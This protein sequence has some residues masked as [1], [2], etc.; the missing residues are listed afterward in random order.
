MCHHHDHH[1]PT[2]TDQ[3]RPST[4]TLPTSTHPRTQ[5]HPPTHSTSPRLSDSAQIKFAYQARGE[6]NSRSPR[7]YQ[8][9][10]VAL[11]NDANNLEAVFGPLPRAGRPGAQEGPGGAGRPP[12]DFILPIKLL[13]PHLFSRKSAHLRRITTARA[14]ASSLS[15]CKNNASL[16][17]L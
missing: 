7:A 10:G 11:R 2:L 16:I 12:G 13:S 9:V 6:L 4:H 17:I 15:W 14:I 5:T 8:K 3:Y 1:S